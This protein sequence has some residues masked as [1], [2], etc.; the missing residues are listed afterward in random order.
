MIETLQNVLLA[1][2]ETVPHLDQYFGY[3]AML[4]EHFRAGVEKARSIDLHVHLATR[5][6]DVALA[7]AIDEEPRMI[8][9]VAVIP[10]SGTMMKTASSMTR[11]TSTVLVRRQI[12][13]AASSSDVRGILLLC[14]SPGGTVSGTQDLAADVAAA[15]GKKKVVALIQDLGA[16]ACYW[17]ASQA[18]ELFA[19][20][21]TT[22]V[23]SIG[24]YGVV[25]DLSAM[26]AKEGIKV[27]VV[28][29]GAHKGMGVP[30]SEI[31]AEQLADYQRVINSLNEQFVQGVAAGR[32]LPLAKVHELADGRVHVGS[33]AKSL[34]LVDD[35][36]S[37]DEVFARFDSQSLHRSRSNS[38]MST[39]QPTQ[40]GA[41]KPAELITATVVNSF[42]QAASLEEL[43]ENLFPAAAIENLSDADNR[44]LM[45][46]LN[47]RATVDSALKALVAHQRQQLAAAKQSNAE[48]DKEIK[49]LRQQGGAGL[50]VDAL[51]DGT[52]A[53]KK[54]PG[55]DAVAQVEEKVTALVT[56]G[57]TP[58]KAR[59]KVFA[60]NP[61]LRVEYV[62]A[63]NEAHGRR[64]Q[65]GAYRESFAD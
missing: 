49:Q 18:T 19:A 1:G 30:G 59:Q 32:R 54:T 46:Q 22:L 63:Y 38:Q 26:A 17:V 5:G 14:D 34:Q 39:T 53:S 20:N 13:Y 36:L 57:M 48:A 65:G 55:G 6:G 11:S 21:E 33:Q 35:V 40:A 29:A 51:G 45:Q 60:D 41:S 58:E 37:L 7:A 52:S 25:H 9:G 64:K 50:G 28:K 61:E 44:F 15:A 27:H 4:E 56:G 31:T 3:W 42:E 24:T 62:A 12:R 8:D 2:V 43:M 47:K 10:L 16:S 23:G